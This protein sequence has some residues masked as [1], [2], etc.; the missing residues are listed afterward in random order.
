MSLELRITINLLDLGLLAGLPG[1]R[2]GWVLGM[3]LQGKPAWFAYGHRG[4]YGCSDNGWRRVW[5]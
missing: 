3:R 5:G 1:L 4:G 2:P